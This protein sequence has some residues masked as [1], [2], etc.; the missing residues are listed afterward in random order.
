M[1]ANHP[2]DTEQTNR[3]TIPSA[4]QS[5][6]GHMRAVAGEVATDAGANSPQWVE[7]AAGTAVRDDARPSVPTARRPAEL[8]EVARRRAAAQQRAALFSHAPGAAYRSAYAIVMTLVVGFFAVGAAFAVW[9]LLK[10]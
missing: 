3:A 7:T 9:V 8:E 2:L 4:P 10:H 6:A 5:A 1:T